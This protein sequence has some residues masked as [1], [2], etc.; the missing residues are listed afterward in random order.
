MG[1][2]KPNRRTHLSKRFAPSFSPIITEP[3]FDDSFR[4]CATL[5][6]PPPPSCASPTVRSATVIVGVTEIVVPGCTRC[7]SIAPDTV[8]ALKVE[9][10]SKFAWMARFCRAYAGAPSMLLA[11]TRG[12]F[13][14]ARISPVR[15][16]ITTAVAPCGVYV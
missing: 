14:R 4:I 6:T 7:S 12:Q 15:G 2:P 16:S 13:A 3:T 5:L 8:I 9:P 10:G 11:S 1:L